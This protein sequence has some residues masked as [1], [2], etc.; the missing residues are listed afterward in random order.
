ME[1]CSHFSNV[2]WCTMVVSQLWEAFECELR[3]FTNQ[4]NKSCPTSTC[5]TSTTPQWSSNKVTYLAYAFYSLSSSR[6]G[7]LL[8][9]GMTNCICIH[10]SRFWIWF[11]ENLNFSGFS[12]FGMMCDFPQMTR[13]F[14]FRDF[15]MHNSSFALRMR[16]SVCIPPR[17]AKFVK[18]VY[19]ELTRTADSKLQKFINLT[20]LI[21][22]TVPFNPICFLH[23]I[24][25]IKNIWYDIS[26][27]AFSMIFLYLSRFS[28]PQN[29]TY[30]ELLSFRNT[31]SGL[32]KPVVN[33]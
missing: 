9:F 31:I 2:N 16:Q 19:T 8:H 28:N 11:P 7:C 1:Y 33:I 17:F 22:V 26:D 32:S 13:N 5:L 24:E 14:W 23:I 12:E 18:S 27:M 15:V 29:E 21:W 3:R 6:Q 4:S 20:Y 10:I 25:L 30:G